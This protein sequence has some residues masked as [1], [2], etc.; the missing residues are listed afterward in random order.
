MSVIVKNSGS[1]QGIDIKKFGGF[2]KV[3]VDKFTFTSR[4][5]FTESITHSLGEKPTFVLILASVKP[6]VKY[7][8]NMIMGFAN[9]PSAY[10]S[11]IGFAY[12]GDASNETYVDTS[13]RLKHNTLKIDVSGGTNLYFTANVEYTLITAV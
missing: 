11:S 2:A 12:N 10:E 4:T 8:I 7:D 3:A 13:V 9:L 6:T 5:A 1:S